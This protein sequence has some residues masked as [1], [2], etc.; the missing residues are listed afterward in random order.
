MLSKRRF[1][2][3]GADSGRHTQTKLTML[4]QDQLTAGAMQHKLF[5]GTGA[6]GSRQQGE[7]LCI[8]QP[9]SNRRNR[10]SGPGSNHPQLKR[11]SSENRHPCR[12]KH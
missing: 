5:G 1:P 6:D 2:T 9:R 12:P 7:R 11:C 10:I 4:Q 3:L 8:T